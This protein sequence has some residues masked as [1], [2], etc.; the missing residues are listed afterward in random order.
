[1]ALKTGGRDTSKVEDS[2]GNP[3]LLLLT[4]GHALGALPGSP[5]LHPLSFF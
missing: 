4:D 1:M 2:E 3:D 5:L